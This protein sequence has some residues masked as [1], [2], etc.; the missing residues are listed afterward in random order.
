MPKFKKVK[1]FVNYVK[2]VEAYKKEFLGIPQFK[3][4]ESAENWD[5]WFKGGESIKNK[6]K[7]FTKKGKKKDAKKEDATK[8][9]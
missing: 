7:G 5:N 2:H 6:L 3:A 1:H 8:K 9:H 4:H